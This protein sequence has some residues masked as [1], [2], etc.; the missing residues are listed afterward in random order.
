MEVMKPYPDSLPQWRQHS[1]KPT[2]EIAEIATE[3]ACHSL[4]ASDLLLLQTEHSAYSFSLTD[5]HQLRGLLMGGVFGDEGASAVLLGAQGKENGDCEPAGVK[6]KEPQLLMPTAPSLRAST[7]SKVAFPAERALR[8]E[9]P[10]P[11]TWMSLKCTFV[12][13]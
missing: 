1:S 13:V 6:L 8:T 11:S 7:F 12:I 10:V 5:A 9:V 4:V 2:F 3:I